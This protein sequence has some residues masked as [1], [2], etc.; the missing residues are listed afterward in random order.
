MDLK[1]PKLGRQSRCSVK[2]QELKK[3]K[4][5]V[6]KLM[7]SPRSRALQKVCANKGDDIQRTFHE[8]N[9]DEELKFV[10]LLRD[11]SDFETIPSSKST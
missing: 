3:N 6:G 5:L 7:V 10:D 2:L 11:L 8:I 1:L 4:S 9:L